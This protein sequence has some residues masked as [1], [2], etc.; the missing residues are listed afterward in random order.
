M[1]IWDI[2]EY[3]GTDIT[4]KFPQIYAQIYAAAGRDTTSFLHLFKFFTRQK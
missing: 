1:N 4:T 3:L 2:V